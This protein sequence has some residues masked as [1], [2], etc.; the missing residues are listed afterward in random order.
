MRLDPL[1]HATWY[2]SRIRACRRLLSRRTKIQ[3]RQRVG[4]A[5]D[6]AFPQILLW[7]RGFATSKL[8][9]SRTRAAG[10]L[11]LERSVLCIW[12]T[13]KIQ[14][15]YRCLVSGRGCVA[16]MEVLDGRA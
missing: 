11:P 14:L 16:P 1:I 2:G 10:E 9:Q 7:H 5:L 13:L 6:S 3:F 8:Q 15:R 4:P 12:L